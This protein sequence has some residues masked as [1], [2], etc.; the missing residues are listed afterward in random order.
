MCFYPVKLRIRINLGGTR[1]EGKAVF[2]LLDYG[3]KTQQ[4]SEQALS[5]H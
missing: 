5:E 1:G 4:E 3:K 2:L